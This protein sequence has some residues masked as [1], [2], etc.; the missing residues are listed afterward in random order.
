MRESGILLPVSALPSQHGIGKIGQRAFEFIDFLREAG[1]HYWQVLPLSPTGYGDSPYQSCSCFAGNPYLISFDAL[2][3]RG[4]LT[5]SDYVGL[6]WETAPDKIDYA[7][8]WQ[9]VIPV[10][11][12]AHT[13]FL[14]HK[15]ADYRK[16]CNEHKAWLPEY[17][18]FMALKDVH[19]GRPWYEWEPELAMRD[20]RVIADARD[21][22]AREIDFYTFV[23][24]CFFSQ[25]KSLKKYAHKNGIRIIGDI[26]I[27]AA[28]DSAEVWAQPEL[29]RLD[30]DK[31]PVAVAGCPPDAFALTGQLWGNPLWDWEKMAEDGYAWWLDR[32]AFVLDLYDLVRIDHFR[33]FEKYYAIPYGA[34]TAEHGKWTKGPDYALWKAAKKRFGEDMPVIAEDL[35]N[36]TPAVERLLRRTGFPGMK[37]MQFAFDSGADNPYL[38]HNF[39]SPN[40]VCYTGTHD[41]H[42]L[43][44]WVKANSGAVNAYTMAYLNVKKEK[45]IPKAM[46][47]AAWSSTARIA[48]AQM[49][50]FLDAPPSARTN[51]PSTLGGN[52]AYRTALSDYTPKLAAKIRRLNATYGRLNAE[53]QP[54]EPEETKETKKAPAKKA[55]PKHTAAK[56]TAQ[57]KDAQNKP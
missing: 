46:I 41:N 34:E 51:T 19:A 5:P 39:T 35:G 1:C 48:V 28:Y 27:Y 8:L 14:Q 12:I 57:K 44:G 17:A 47:R 9:Q 54:A 32:I 24:Y 31:K 23:Q 3:A 7:L 56:R 26:P 10:L 49:Q 55:S 36:I 38:P 43:R 53:P 2:T 40:C 37:V 4:W 22:Y 42:T 15:P 29:F 18:L 52:W 16:F 25:W 13:R 6:P 11:R 21:H 50:D 30:K 33:G 45:Q 20:R